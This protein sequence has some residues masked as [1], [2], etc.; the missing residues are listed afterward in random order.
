MF[1]DIREKLRKMAE[2]EYRKFSE[3][4]VPGEESMLGIRLPDLR[5][6][7]KEIGKADWQSYLEEFE[8]EEE[9]FFEEIMLY[10][11]V[12]G[13]AKM[14]IEERKERILTFIPKIHNW[15]VCDSCCMTYKWMIK[16]REQWYDFLKAQL[17][18]GE[19]FR[20]RFGLVALLDYFVNEEYVDRVLK[21][22]EE[23]N[24][25]GYYAKMAAAWAVSVCCA[26]FPEK[27][28]QF[29][30]NNQMD[31]WIQNKS[32]QKCRESYRVTKEQK[33]RLSQLKR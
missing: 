21:H 11:M 27:T 22:C 15:S 19:E 24:H 20:I 31:D 17:E 5:T 28:E 8:Q 13:Y 30:Q 33:E 18:S 14:D 23:M 10:G 4:L 12:I 9:H 29:L 2:E 16:D 26:K 6:L 25:Q 32:I 7:A 3:G 1:Q